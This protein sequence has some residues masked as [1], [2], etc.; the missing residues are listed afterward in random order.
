MGFADNKKCSTSNCLRK[1]I[2]TLITSQMKEKQTL[3]KKNK[4][5]RKE[6]SEM[7]EWV[8]EL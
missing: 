3:F 2:R 5:E 8:S 1:K 7:S 4:R 6:G